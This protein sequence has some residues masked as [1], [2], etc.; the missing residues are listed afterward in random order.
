MY[1]SFYVYRTNMSSYKKYLCTQF[2]D[3]VPLFIIVVVTFWETP[4][5]KV[6]NRSGRN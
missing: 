6:N 2:V 5:K 3:R 4:K 1:V